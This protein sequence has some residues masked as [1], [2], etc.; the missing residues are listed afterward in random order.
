MHS[1]LGAPGGSGVRVTGETVYI[2]GAGLGGAL[3]ALRG[4]ATVSG[5]NVW[6]G[7]VIFTANPTRI[8]TED[9][10]NLTISG[11]I[12]D[13]SYNYNLLF[14]PGYA[15]TITVS[16][17][18]NYWGGSADILGSDVSSKVILGVHNALPTNSL[19]TVGNATLDLNGFHQASAGLG[20]NGTAGSSLVD[21]TGA[22][23]MLTLKPAVDRTFAGTVQGN[24]SLVKEG[25]NS[26]T[27][28]GLKAY[29]GSTAINGAQIGPVRLSVD[30]MTDAPHGWPDWVSD[31]CS[32]VGRDV[33]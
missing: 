17:T 31:I 11:N 28:S 33:D 24:L 2:A 1:L 16:G 7:P 22:A 15:G 12:T 19:I 26:Q 21:N 6:D 5:S 9:N 3:G 4:A 27:L 14:R 8:G 25:T 20:L 13:R 18:S 29:T 10:G 30:H 32:A 23:A